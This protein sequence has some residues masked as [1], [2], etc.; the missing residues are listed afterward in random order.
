MK[1]A[2]EPLSNTIQHCTNIPLLSFTCTNAVAKRTLV[3]ST[4]LNKEVE[5]IGA[6]S[7]GFKLLIEGFRT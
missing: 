1:F 4:P 3:L 6:S 7:L 2:C 5:A